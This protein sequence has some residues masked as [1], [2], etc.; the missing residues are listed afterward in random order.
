ME[1][2][3][4]DCFLTRL[5]LVIVIFFVFQFQK[6]CFRI[7]GAKLIAVTHL[8]YCLLCASLTQPSPCVFAEHFATYFQ[9]ST[10]ITKLVALVSLHFFPSFAFSPCMLSSFFSVLFALLSALDII[11][12]S[13]VLPFVFPSFCPLE[14]LL[15]LRERSCEKCFTWGVK[16]AY[17]LTLWQVHAFILFGPHQLQAV[18]TFQAKKKVL[19]SQSDGQWKWWRSANFWKVGQSSPPWRSLF[20]A[21]LAGCHAKVA[22]KPVRTLEW[23]WLSASKNWVDTCTRGEEQIDWVHH[24]QETCHTQF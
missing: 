14:G 20:P 6:L 4:F 7:G 12:C 8:N 16:T 3:V 23:K 10:T 9:L 11:S 22:W 1:F 21:W 5:F 15:T 17:V 18:H 13:F 19:L 2:L 24:R